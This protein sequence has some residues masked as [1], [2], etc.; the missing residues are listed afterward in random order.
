ET[1]TQVRHHVSTGHL[2]DRLDMAGILGNENN[3]D[4]G[5]K[6]NGATVKLR[7]REIRKADDR[8]IAHALQVYALPVDTEYSAA[9]GAGSAEDERNKVADSGADQNWQ[10]ANE[11]LA[12][13]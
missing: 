9:L 7:R 2:R 12:K 13:N 10:S 8:G 11:A 5:K 1:S 6:P 4:R 3:G